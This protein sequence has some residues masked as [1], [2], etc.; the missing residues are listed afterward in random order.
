[1][2]NDL[3]IVKIQKE[4]NETIRGLLLEKGH[5]IPADLIP[6]AEKFISGYRLRWCFY[7]V[8]ARRC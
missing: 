3:K 4:S 2:A 7:Q 5:L 8:T 1:M 6:H